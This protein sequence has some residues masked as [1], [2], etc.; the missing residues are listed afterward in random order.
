MIKALSQYYLLGNHDESAYARKLLTEKFGGTFY[1]FKKQNDVYVVFDTQKELGDIPREQI[2]FLEKTIEENSKTKK[3][4][5]FMHELL[6][7]AK[8]VEYKNIYPNRG[9]A[10]DSNFWTEF[11]PVL[12]KNKSKNFYIVAGDVGANAASSP[13][14]REKIDNVTFL[15]SGMG[16]HKDE[17]Y[18]LFSV[19]GNDVD[20]FFVLLNT[21]KILS[22]TEDIVNQENRLQQ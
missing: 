20:I 4:F 1:S 14:F 9:Y 2:E 15:A 22:S 12:K 7:T 21:G 11:Y 18:L 17:N 3:F 5:L 10:F 13:V 8:K 6:W 16:G 19:N